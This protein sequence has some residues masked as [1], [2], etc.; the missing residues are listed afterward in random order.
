VQEKKGREMAQKMTLTAYLEQRGM[1]AKALKRG[2]A[3][4][5]GIPYPLRAGWPSRHG[6]MEITP[7][8]IDDANARIQAAKRD[9]RE[10]LRCG[11]VEVKKPAPVLG[12]AAAPPVMLSLF[13]G[14]A[15]RQARRYQGRRA[16]P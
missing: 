6:Q 3:E 13:P 9:A 16:V 12:A 1:K 8:M 10:R 14:F 7:A 15:S 4:A 5:F 2:E 11:Q